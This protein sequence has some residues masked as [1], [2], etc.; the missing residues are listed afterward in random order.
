MCTLVSI[1]C[2]HHVSENTLKYTID[3]QLIPYH[4]I[5]IH[6][7]KKKQESHRIVTKSIQNTL[8]YKRN[9]DTTEVCRK[10]KP[11]FAHSSAYPKV[12]SS[13]HILTYRQKGHVFH[14]SQSRTQ[15][16]YVY[17]QNLHV[18]TKYLLK[19]SLINTRVQF[20]QLLNVFCKKQKTMGSKITQKKGKV[21]LKKGTFFLPACHTQHTAGPSW[22]GLAHTARKS[23][24]RSL[25]W[26]G[27]G[28]PACRSRK[29]KVDRR[30]SPPAPTP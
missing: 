13:T 9:I 8:K 16:W 7:K 11:H 28:S 6:D 20:V 21:T 5:D 12:K 30:R 14:I 2:M 15:S 10:R 22:I 17:V 29:R 24:V 1:C 19:T 26:P 3:K 23:S 25:S 18:C 27:L 4:P